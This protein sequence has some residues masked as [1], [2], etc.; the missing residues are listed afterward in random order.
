MERDP[1][2]EQCD[3]HWLQLNEVATGNQLHVGQEVP[4]GRVEALCNGAHRLPLLTPFPVE[5]FEFPAG[6]R[7]RGMPLF[8]RWRLP[9]K[10]AA[11]VA[12]AAFLYTLLRDV[13]HPYV[14]QGRN[15]CYR[16][17]ILV[18]NK[19][20]PWS[21]I[22]LL[23]LVYLPGVLA[24][25]LQLHRG[26]K[27]SRFPGWLDRW[28]SM[29]KQLGLI[30]FFLASLH[31]IYSLCYPMRRSYRYKLLNWAYQQVKQDKAD[32]WVEDDVWRM[33]IY[34]SLGI[35][36]LAALALVAISSLPSVSDA[37]N[38]REFQ[39]VQRSLGY[40]ALL[41]A[42]AHALVYGWRKWVEPKHFVWYTPP[43]FILASLLPGVVLLAKGAL[44]LPCVDRKL[45]RIR[46]GWERPRPLPLPPR[47]GGPAKQVEP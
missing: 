15:E 24:A 12:G 3:P 1:E 14:S 35:L 10:L 33:E 11:S 29:R 22:T 44:L 45:G 46:R 18:M 17:P 40:S 36:G 23:A 41:L 19:T 21:S 39:C 13:L 7:L 42:T 6:V 34:V 2:E 20:L 8:P 26:T 9:L 37:L 47:Q 16:I 31:A 5:D 27:Y 43:S 4:E 38:W 30:A 28:L 25:G 32:A